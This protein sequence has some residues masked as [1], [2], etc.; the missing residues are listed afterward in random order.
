VGFR[1]RRTIK[2]GKGLRINLSKSGV[3]LSAGRPGA[4][5]NIGSRGAATTVGIPGT[6]LSYRSALL[7]L[8]SPGKRT[9][10]PAPSSASPGAAL[11]C[12]GAS[13]VLLGLLL[14]LSGVS[15]WALLLLGLGALLFLL[16]I[17]A[18][19]R[20]AAF[21]SAEEERTRQL[22]ALLLLL[23]RRAEAQ[24]RASLVARFGEEACSRILARDV[25][26]GQTEEQLREALGEPVD[27]DEKV[28]KT[29]RREVWKY[30]QTGASRFKTRVILEGGLVAG[31]DRK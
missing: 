3:S 19:K 22:A 14:L 24:R 17:R 26:L 20:A 2:L 27:I 18:S 12:L 10:R 29:K 13:V 28:M 5:L 6:G 16:Q 31:W 4:S 9:S 8:R 15:T 23:Q 25:W 11:G 30:D 7:H 21:R 1:F